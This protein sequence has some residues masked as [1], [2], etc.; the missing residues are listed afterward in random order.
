MNATTDSGRMMSMKFIIHL[1]SQEFVG[2]S[3]KRVEMVLVMIRYGNG[4]M[5][6][7]ISGL[8]NFS[9]DQ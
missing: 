4:E 9:G 6:S 2:G 3:F 8:N 5:K 1:E 7:I